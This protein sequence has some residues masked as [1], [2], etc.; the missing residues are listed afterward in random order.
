MV[1]TNWVRYGKHQV[2]KSSTTLLFV[3]ALSTPPIF[4]LASSG[5]PTLLAS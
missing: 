1:G 4:V 3:T 2:H 5:P